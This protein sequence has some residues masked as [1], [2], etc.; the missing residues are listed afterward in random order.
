MCDPYYEDCSVAEEE[1]TTEDDTM[2]AEEEESTNSI[3]LGWGLIPTLDLMAGAY[4]YDT[5][6]DASSDEWDMAYYAELSIGTLA[7]VMWSGATFMEDG[8]L[9]SI[10]PI[11]SKVHVGLEGLLLYLVYDAEDVM[12]NDASVDN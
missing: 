9:Y 12:P 7:L 6:K 10:F 1:P 2:M 5:W 3:L 11:Y 4:N 8:P